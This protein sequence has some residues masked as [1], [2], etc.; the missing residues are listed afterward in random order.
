MIIMH[1]EY[2][3]N[4]DMKIIYVE[5]DSI[6]YYFQIVVKKIVQI[7]TIVNTHNQYKIV[8]DVYD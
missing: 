8:F 1:G 6:M 4:F 7:F 5:T 3:E 2:D